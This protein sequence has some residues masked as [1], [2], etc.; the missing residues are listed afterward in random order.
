VVAR[1][2]R[3]AGAPLLVAGRDWRVEGARTELRA[4]GPRTSFDVRFGRGASVDGLELP[5]LGVHQAG[6]AA[7]AVM[8]VLEL[9][10]RGV[11]DGPLAC[12][13]EGIRRT[14][15]PAR[16][17]VAGR[18]PLVIVDG[19]HNGAS[20]RA[21]VKAVRAVA[22]PGGRLLVVFAANRDKDLR[23]MLRAFRGRARV[24]ATEVDNPRR[25]EAGELVRLARAEGL[26][27]SAAGPPRRALAA[28]RAAARPGDTVLVTGSMYLAGAVR[29]RT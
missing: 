5:M 12:L 25:A 11:L 2:C 28:A 6:N 19:A 9:G 10:R 16:L 14:R 17:E 13:W 27:A 21:A 29:A 18:R 7:L 24:F 23:G 26:A 20:V 4:D 15:V 1:L 22:E 8:A 3:R